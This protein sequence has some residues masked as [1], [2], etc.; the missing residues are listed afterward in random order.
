MRQ[1]WRGGV[2]VGNSTTNERIST[3]G[4]RRR[5]SRL[6]TRGQDARIQTQGRSDERGCGSSAE[7]SRRKRILVS[8][9]E[10]ENKWAHVNEKKPDAESSK[11]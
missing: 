11:T 1:M 5:V 4:A 3:N 8:L 10:G 9:S 7:I 2:E 6:S